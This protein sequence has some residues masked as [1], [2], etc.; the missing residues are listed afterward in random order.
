MKIQPSSTYSFNQFSAQNMLISE[1]MQG[2]DIVQGLILSWVV[3]HL[4]AYSCIWNCFCF[5]GRSIY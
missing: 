2:A 3:G 5:L 4:W 1:V